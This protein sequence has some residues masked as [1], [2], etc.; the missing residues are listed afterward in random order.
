MSL[1]CFLWRVLFFLLLLLN[2]MLVFI[3]WLSSLSTMTLWP[4][5]WLKFSFFFSLLLLWT[6]FISFFD[7]LLILF[8]CLINLLCF[9]NLLSIFRCFVLFCFLIFLY[10]CSRYWLCSLLSLPFFFDI[11][12]CTFYWLV[13]ICRLVN[14]LFLLFFFF[15][16]LSLHLWNT[17]WLYSILCHKFWLFN[18]L[19]SL[20]L[21]FFINLSLLRKL[22]FLEFLLSLL[23]LLN[24]LICR[25]VFILFM[26]SFRH[27]ILKNCFDPNSYSKK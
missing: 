11:L 24:C 9:T 8:G 16:S 13:N 18:L 4:V 17:C 12:L 20:G 15:R 3:G 22:L 5:I 19:G 21:Y 23:F 14:D 27:L 25:F 7:V 6:V 2:L 1:Q 26:L 10:L